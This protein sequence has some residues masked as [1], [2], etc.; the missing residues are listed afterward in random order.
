MRQLHAE[1]KSNFNWWEWIQKF[2]FCVF[3]ILNS[4]QEKIQKSTYSNYKGSWKHARYVI[5]YWMCTWL[6]V[7]SIFKIFK[8]LKIHIVWVYMVPVR[9]FWYQNS[10]RYLYL[11]IYTFTLTSLFYNRCT[12]TILKYYYI[13]P[14]SNFYW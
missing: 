14:I 9:K 8:P 6:G 4:L 12:R 1:T 5:V 3:H 10:I 11:D 13:H 7:N 2:F